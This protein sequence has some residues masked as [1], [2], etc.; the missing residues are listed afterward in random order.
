M[1]LPNFN[2]LDSARRILFHELAR[3][4]K[5]REARRTDSGNLDK[6][7]REAR[8]ECWREDNVVVRDERIA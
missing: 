6:L 4:D 5:E 8:E 7:I 1:G 2:S 3:D